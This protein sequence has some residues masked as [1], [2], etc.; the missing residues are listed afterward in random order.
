MLGTDQFP[1]IE[2]NLEN[3]NETGFFCQKRKRKSLGFRQKM[4]WVT[5]SFKNG[6]KIKI[7]NRG[8]HQV[9]FIEY[10]PGEY[11][12]RVVEAPDFM[13]IHC[14]WVIGPAKEK[15]IGKMLGE[16][17]MCDARSLGKKGVVMVTTRGPWPANKELFV[18]MWFETTSRAPPSF[19]LLVKN[20]SKD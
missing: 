5:K 18:Q 15:G 10:I 3:A 16:T 2:V 1:V 17:C 6:P 7:V 14:L 19:E 20:W 4:D 13:V 8:N 9:G 11:T 12:W